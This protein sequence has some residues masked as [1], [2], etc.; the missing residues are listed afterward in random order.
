MFSC[1][2]IYPLPYDGAFSTH[3]SGEHD[4]DR[5]R[6]ALKCLNKQGFEYATVL[7]MPDIMHSQSS[8]RH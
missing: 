2:S 5:L 4:H 6:R 1:N 3:V 7:N 8:L